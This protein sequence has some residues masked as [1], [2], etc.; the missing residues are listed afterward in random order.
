MSRHLV[1]PFLVAGAVLAAAVAAHPAAAQSKDPFGDLDLNSLMKKGGGQ[2]APAPAPQSPTTQQAKPGNPP[3][4]SRDDPI[5]SLARTAT[6]DRAKGVYVGKSK[7]GTVA[8]YFREEG[9][10]HRLDIG[11]AAAGAFVRLQTPEPR[12]ATATP[13][14]RVFAGKQ[15]T[16]RVGDNEFAT[17]EYAVLKAYGGPVEFSVPDPKQGGFTVLT[18]TDSKGFL[19][20]VAAAKG[21]FVVVQSAQGGQAANIVAVYRFSTTLI[22]VLLSCANAQRLAAAEPATTAAP[23]A[24]ASG[25]EGWAVYTNPRFGITID[26]PAVIF[27]KR[28]RPP[29]NGDG[30]TF[31]S[32][33]GNAQLSVYGA[34]N[35]DNDTPQSYVAKYVDR[36]GVSFQRV[37]ANFFA[38][39]GVRDGAIFYQRCN[40]PPPP[41]DVVGCFVVTYEAEQKAMW[42]PIVDRLSR[43]LR[44]AQDHR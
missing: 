23:A 20:M 14:V 17:G 13:P 7:S 16:R 26:Y 4:V 31:R 44:S 28:D 18:R 22:P 9:D 32:A 10:S 5:G 34:Y 38:V 24:A 1:V 21:E 39:S 35:V 40:F 42:N 3:V 29:E 15:K 8:C 2:P 36:Q 33:D 6:F 11:I 43:S 41:G 27:S 30:Q 12:D 25:Q 37:T 19:E